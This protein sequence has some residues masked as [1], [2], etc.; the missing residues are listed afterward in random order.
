MSASEVFRGRV[1]NLHD[2]REIVATSRGP[3][4][5]VA[6]VNGGDGPLVQREL[7]GLRAELFRKDGQVSV[8]AHQERT[9]RGQLLGLLDALRARREQLGPLDPDGVAL[10]IMMPGK[11][12]RLSPLTQRLYGIKPFLPMLIRP[13]QDGGRLLHGAGASLWT[14]TLVAHHLARLGF[15]GI[16]WKWGDEPQIAANVLAELDL[17]LEDADAVRFG[18]KMTV[19]E[20]LA[21]N[22]EWL[23][24]DET[25][26]LVK[27]VRRRGREELLGA[28]GID[29]PTR[30][31]RALVHVGSPAFSHVFLAA[32]EE[33]FGDAEGWL[34]VDGYL[35]EALTHDADAWATEIERDPGL[36]AL[37]ETHPDFYERAEALA[38]A[39]EARRGRKPVF[40]VVDLGEGLYWGD[41]GQ[42]D[43][44]RRSL[45]EVT[46]RGEDGRF[47]R[48]LAALDDLEPD[49]HGNIATGESLYPLDGSVRNSVLIDAEIHGSASIDG[50]V[51]VGS[52]LGEAR[53]GAGTVIL[54]STV[55]ELDA[56]AESL[57]F[58]AFAETLALGPREVVT[59]IPVD[60]ADLSRGVEAWRADTTVDVGSA[61]L[62]AK[63][64]FGN[65]ASFAEKFAQMRG[66]SVGPVEVERALEARF[67]AP[68]Q[69][70]ARDLP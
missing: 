58:R 21:R 37:L 33:V 5:V 6:I 28:F 17:D 61:D 50:A 41:V 11:G 70:R 64:C 35:F 55:L 48:R 22:K 34:D 68:L 69:E 59:Y 32:A 26:R 57:V 29:D 16:A 54:Q 13:S 23:F 25:G 56:G 49:A 15:R 7:D 52:Q 18:A 1:A 38:G 10:G 47:A 19:T 65:P 53:V 9:R 27:Q 66:R 63:P 45:L 46:A 31:V 36:R 24:S 62:Y 20:D 3:T 42:L 44:A 43:K 2:L 40:K 60:P 39:I 12:T 67:R 8:F 51:I 4:Q 14:W 30:D